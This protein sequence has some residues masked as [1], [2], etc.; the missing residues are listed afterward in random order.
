[1]TPSNETCPTAPTR[2]QSTSSGTIPLTA[3]KQGQ[4]ARIIKVDGQGAFRKRILEMG[5]VHQRTVQMVETA[6]MGDPIRFNL[7][8]YHVSL[9]REEA[10]LVQ[11]EPLTSEPHTDPSPAGANSIPN[12][13]ESP[14]EPLPEEHATKHAKNSKSRPRIRVAL[15]GNPNAGKTTLFNHASGARNHTGNYGGVTVDSSTAHFT[16][17]GIRYELTDLPGTYSITPYSPE[18]KFVENFLTSTPPDVILNVVDCNNLE[19]NLYLTLQ[20]LEIGIPVVIALNMW[21]EFQHKGHRL[22]R[23]ALAH[24]LG[25]PCIPTNGRTGEGIDRVLSAI[26][27]Q[28][29]NG[30][31]T[32]P[33]LKNDYTPHIHEALNIIRASKASPSES[34]T[35]P[36]LHALLARLENTPTGHSTPAEQ[37]AERQALQKLQQRSGADPQTAVTNARYDAIH[38]LLRTTLSAAQPDQKRARKRSIDAILTHRIWGLPIFLLLMWF[39]FYVTFTLGEVPMGWIEDAIAW[40]A[41][42]VAGAMPPGPLTDL[43][44]DGI[45]AGIGGVIVFLPQIMI[46]FTCIAIMEDTGYMAR[47]VFLVDRIMRSFGLHGRSLIPLVMGF[48]CNVPAMMA[49][50]T[51]ENRSVRLAT[52]LT[53][54]FMSCSARLPVYILLVPILFPG[55]E[56]LTL[57]ALYTLGILVAVLLAL[58]F[59]KTFLKGNDTPFVL[60]LPPYRIPTLR[61]ALRHMWDKAVQYLKKMGSVILVASIIIW[62]LGYFPRPKT[63]TAPLALQTAPLSATESAIDP[64]E[65]VPHMG[66]MTE[67]HPNEPASVT[68]TFQPSPEQ[69]HYRNSYLGRMGRGVEPLIQPLGFD[70]RIGVALLSG[71]AAKEVVVSTMALVFQV[72]DDG[73]D[74]D[75]STLRERIQVVTY[76]AGPRAGQIIF[77]PHTG[78]ALLVFVAL[79]IPCIAV[80]SGIRKEAGSWKWAILSILY[81]TAIAYF[82]ALIIFQIGEL[83]V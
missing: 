12:E 20:L 70:W 49:T 73:L 35:A 67:A 38:K 51:I 79:Y 39:M 45:I 78:L 1:M 81:T 83:F 64:A 52:I 10:Q 36:S 50:R 28:H 69:E 53:L 14:S 56:A 27:R 30:Y 62:A 2:Q 55:Y 8:G 65:T 15:L 6:P 59:R 41:A 58:I 29:S 57:F 77:A 9:R 43:I 42:T 76:D 37:Q 21:D 5:F 72:P 82:A 19:R 75:P 60:E 22:N 4:Y 44:C 74:E 68:D 16:H 71:I 34:Q 24:A 40:L 23:P 63:D 25:T 48:G 17:N 11:V 3:L 18:E 7:M 46:L 32:P 54:P 80:I 26:Q 61:S 13:P 66:T 31:A 33:I 47:A